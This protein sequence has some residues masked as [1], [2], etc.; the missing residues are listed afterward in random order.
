MGIN[1]RKYRRLYGSTVW[2][3][4]I[5][6]IEKYIQKID[7]VEICNGGFTIREEDVGFYSKLYK[8]DDRFNTMRHV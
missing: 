8:K 1:R 6:D 2:F 4:E 5:S 7:A 3:T